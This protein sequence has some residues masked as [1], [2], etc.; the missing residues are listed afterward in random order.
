MYPVGASRKVV[1]APLDWGLGHATRIIPIIRYLID[2]GRLVTVAATPAGIGVIRPEFPDLEYLTIPG[3]RMDYPRKGTL[4]LFHMIR[5]LPRIISS[6]LKEYLWL[7]KAQRLHRWDLIISDNRYGFRHPHVLSVFITHQI[8]IR[9]EISSVADR[10]VKKINLALIRR[11]NECWIPDEAAWPGLAGTLS[12]G[13]IPPRARYIGPLSRLTPLSDLQ[14][15]GLLIMLSGPEPQRTLLE[16]RILTALNNYAGTVT[17]VRGLPVAT[18]LPSVRDGQII[19]NHLPAETLGRCM[20]GAALVICRAGYSSVM[21]LVCTGT[22]AVLI[23]TPGQ[24]EQEYLARHLEAHGFFPYMDQADFTIDTALI[25]AE[26]FNF[27]PKMPDFQTYLR[28]LSEILPP[29]HDS[30][31]P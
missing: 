7:R 9:T 30:E 20:A 27:R 22:P 25:R 15:S 23:P 5:R 24:T 19:L 11:F 18:D 17:L 6:M 26:T 28:E 21:D 16:S 29:L 31:K 3:Y 12:H 8:N 2:S 14:R 4:F 13:G 1:I 10:L